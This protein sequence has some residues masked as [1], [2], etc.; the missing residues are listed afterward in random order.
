MHPLIR[1][2][3]SPAGFV[4]VGLLFLLPF[5][6]ASCGDGT[7][8]VTE[9]YTGIDLG[10]HRSP[11]IDPLLQSELDLGAGRSPVVPATGT[12]PGV[13]RPVPVEGAV[14]AAFG[15]V[16]VGVLT[17]LLRRPW[18]RALT[19]VAA[20]GV[21]GILLTGGVLHARKVVLAQVSVDAAPLLGTPAAG[22]P[23]GITAYLDYGFWVV[24][25][26]LAVLLA[27]NVA[28]LVRISRQPAGDPAEQPL[29]EGAG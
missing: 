9:S 12:A 1:R 15:A 8:A 18:S 11:Q 20:A 2:L 28:S 27:G 16:L 29:P 23:S 5:V 22:P 25:G 3:L 26:A 19:G 24:I 6:T 10:A 13:P 4:L 14:A 17:A 21:A 7:V